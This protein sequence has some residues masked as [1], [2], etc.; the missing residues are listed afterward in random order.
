MAETCDSFCTRCGQGHS[1]F[2]PCNEALC[3]SDLHDG[4]RHESEPEMIKAHGN[5]GLKAIDEYTHDFYWC[6]PL[7]LCSVV[8][9]MTSTGVPPPAPVLWRLTAVSERVCAS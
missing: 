3:K 5:L 2:L 1:H 6:V 8:T 9:H 7:L 4:V